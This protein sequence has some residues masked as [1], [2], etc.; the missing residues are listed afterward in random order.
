ME[1]RYCFGIGLETDD[2]EYSEEMFTKGIAACGQ[3]LLCVGTH[4]GSILIFSMPTESNTLNNVDKVHYHP[5]AISDLCG[6]GQNLI[7]GDD[8]GN[9][10]VWE[11]STTL[12]KVKELESF[13]SPATSIACWKELV[14]VGYGSGHIRLFNITT[15]NKTA[16][17][18]AHASWI[19]AV[20]IA[21]ESGLAISVSEDSFVR[22]WQ[23][24]NDGSPVVS[25]KFSCNVTN[26]QVCGGCFVNDVGSAFCTTGYDSY[27]IL[28]FH[29]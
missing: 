1:Q 22:V 20:D 6:Q 4:D 3:N 13:Q 12:K 27:E 21:L 15:G 16:E 5:A 8:Q 28:Y 11:G 26:V 14:M 29:M 10:V 17:I 18:T 23:L 25:N 9:L 24:K 2:T 7:S 19:T